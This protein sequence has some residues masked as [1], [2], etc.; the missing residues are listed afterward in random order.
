VRSV[1]GKRLV[2]NI[3]YLRIKQF[4]QG[5]HDELLDVLGSL[6]DDSAK[7]LRGVVLDMRGN[8]GGLVDE[9][10]AV[11]DEFLS[12]GGIYSTRHR[13]KIDEDVRAHR[14]GALSA[15]PI[16]TL[17]NEY[18]ASASAHAP[19]EKAPCRPSTP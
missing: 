2:D 8:P 13:G 7:P 14:G 3:A 15:L 4:Q 6:R 12:E 18:S 16:V 19:L 1:E 17:V 10:Q 9:A 5:T 11:A